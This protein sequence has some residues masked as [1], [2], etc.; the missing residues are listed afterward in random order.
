MRDLRYGI[1][2]GFEELNVCHS[3]SEE[4]REWWSCDQDRR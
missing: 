4:G 2:R 1:G 3:S